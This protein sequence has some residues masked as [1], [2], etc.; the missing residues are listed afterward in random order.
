MTPQAFHPRVKSE[1]RRPASPFR[2][3]IRIW[4]LHEGRI[5]RMLSFT[6][7]SQCSVG[8]EGRF[9]YKLLDHTRYARGM[10]CPTGSVD[11][12]LCNVLPAMQPGNWVEVVFP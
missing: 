7:Y 12:L 8:G 6:D 3:C 5:V 2:R 11:F 4:F 1:R 10:R 9:F